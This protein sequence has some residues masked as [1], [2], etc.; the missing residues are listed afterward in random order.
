MSTLRTYNLQNPDSSNVNI[1]LTQGSGAVVAGVATFSSNVTV[2]G[3]LTVGGELTYED[4]TNVDSVGLITAR[5]GISITGGDLTILDAIIH[6][7]DT[8][9]R[10]RFPASD[11]FTVETAGNERLRITSNGSVGIGTDNP[12]QTLHLYGSTT[13]ASFT[14]NDDTGESGILF[15]RHDNNQNRGKVTYSFTDD[16]LL[17]RASNNDSGENL[18][19]TSGG[20]VGVGI[21]VPARLLHLHES[22]SNEA[23][24]SFTTP[25]TGATA[26]DGFRVGMNGSEEAIVWN[27]ESGIIKFGTANT[28]RLRITSAGQVNINASSESIGG[29]VVIK[30]NVDY[31]ATDFDDDPTLYLLNGDQTT[32]ISEAAIILAGRN[33]SGSTYRAA[34]SG[35]GSSGIK[36]HPSNNAEL[37][38]TPAMLIN[39]SNR[40]GINV[41]SPDD[42]LHVKNSSD[43]ATSIRIQTG[44]S[45]TSNGDEY[46]SIV[47][48]GTGYVGGKIASH[49]DDGTWDDRG[50][51]RF[52]SGYGNNVFTERMRITNTG[53]IGIGVDPANVLHIKND[54]PI[55]RLESSATS[56]VGRNT[57]GQYQSGLYIDCDNDN[58]I[59]NSFTAFSVDGTERLRIT[60]AGK[61]GINQ[62]S[63][64]GQLHI[65]GNTDESANPSIILDDN[66][67][68]RRCYVTNSSGDMML[69]GIDSGTVQSRLTIHE[70]GNMYHQRL[71]SS[72][73][74]QYQ[75]STSTSQTGGA[76]SGNTYAEHMAFRQAD[77]M[78]H[79]SFT[80]TIYGD[81]GDNYMPVLFI[82]HGY[83]PTNSSFGGQWFGEMWLNNPGSVNPQDY[84]HTGYNNWATTS[85][86]YRW[87]CAHWNAKPTMSMIEHYVNYGR[88]NIADLEI[89]GTTSYFV[90]W[91]LPSVYRVTYSAWD[92]LNA[93][94]TNNNNVGGALTHREGGGNTT[95]AVRA[96]SGRDTRYDSTISWGAQGQT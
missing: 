25:T 9:T 70:N 19:I 69:G 88:P 71:N 95:R 86:K 81:G 30:N 63:P 56:Y 39:S 40:I 36:F 13:F 28:E 77:G 21:S 61:I 72:G 64:A 78:R 65:K 24:I 73:S 76:A 82:R 1:E 51:L 89:S 91:L 67:D 11:T 18:R 46:S 93:W 7:S 66:G 32:G 43:A 2:S 68:A 33:T 6:D 59:S 3:N 47:F 53:K 23:L 42:P 80:M 94:W 85:F 60:S 26:S 50:D 34:I 16:A 22:N 90:I 84:N 4:V 83:H 75:F 96:Y 35:N 48:E 8:N 17:F 20:K 14:N 49:R 57:I 31:T 27:N 52:Y 62:T 45:S 79:G 58:A 38:H 12:D 44:K 92:G 74:L 41:T 37:D 29:K 55:I 10:I 5:N 15:R 54:S 87:D